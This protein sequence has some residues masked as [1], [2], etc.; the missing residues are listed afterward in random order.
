[1]LGFRFNTPGPYWL[2]DAG[3]FAIDEIRALA[4][5][6][7]RGWAGARALAGRAPAWV[8][9]AI[10]SRNADRPAPPPVVRPVARLEETE[11][12]ALA[13]EPLAS[14]DAT[15]V[16]AFA[17]HKSAAEQIDAL[18]YALAQIRNDVRPVM[19]SSRFADEPVPMQP[20]EDALEHSIQALLELSRA[21]AATRPKDRRR[22]VA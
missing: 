16:R 5:R 3:Y 9:A 14:A 11:T 18:S 1:M 13:T 21:N 12:W 17:Y 19:V 7:K 4:R 22:I 6:A 10:E 8:N 2:E 20:A 15:A